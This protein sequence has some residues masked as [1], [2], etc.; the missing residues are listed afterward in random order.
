MKANLSEYHRQDPFHLVIN[1]EKSF[2]SFIFVPKIIK[3]PRH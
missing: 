2:F 1:H 3:S